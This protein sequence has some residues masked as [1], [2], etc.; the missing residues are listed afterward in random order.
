MSRS[1][2]LFFSV[3][4]GIAS[5]D[6]VRP[7]DFGAVGDGMANDR[8]AIAKAFATVTGGG[9]IEFGGGRTYYLGSLALS[10]D[11]AVSC[12]GAAN[13][14]VNGN[15]A[16]L[17]VT[18]TAV[19]QPAILRFTNPSNI[20]ISNLQFRDDGADPAAAKGAVAVRLLGDGL[21]GESH[22]VVIDN[23]SG[24]SLLAF[25]AVGGSSSHR[26]NGIA[27]RDCS[28]S[29]AYY[30]INCQNNGDGLR[31]SGFHTYNL[32]RA[33]FPYGVT[34]HDVEMTVDH[35]D[36]SL[37][38]D[39]CCL[40]KCYDRDTTG[41]KLR[42]RFVGSTVKY[43]NAVTFEHQRSTSVGGA[44]S[45]IDIGLEIDAPSA[46]IP[47]RFR[48]YHD[49]GP[50]TYVEES[51]TAN[52]ITDIRLSGNLAT[53][54]AEVVA[55]GALRCQGVTPLTPVGVE[56]RITVAAGIHQQSM[57][58]HF[59]GCVVVT[60]NGREV[61][62]AKGALSS[63]PILIP[64]AGL[65]GEPFEIIITTWAQDDL[66]AIATAKRTYR[67]DVLFCENATGLD[68]AASKVV[69]L[70]ASNRNGAATI[71]YSRSGESLAV[72]VTGY[73]GVNGL[74]RVE[75]EYISRSP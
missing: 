35:D 33:Y 68:V 43:V 59:P 42:V 19:S 17:V 23:C 30:G 4:A 16:K 58:P 26:I 56:G 12:S 20:R 48:S 13:V 7:E 63:Q 25:L 27:V 69:N 52:R 64:L 31:V 5:A 62:T 3:L 37:G 72:S 10:A 74:A 50:G 9:V 51:A 66:A 75:V 65:D 61:R 60:G 73:S 41:L 46:M 44:I 34:N 38:Q 53:L 45:G 29:N 54:N 24:D 71:S 11:A 8:V 39:T 1:L 32:R 15:G 57:N 22:G 40:I 21:S 14:I 55:F 18:T 49:T 70:A 47:V 67:R 2:M 6:T 28:I 36:T